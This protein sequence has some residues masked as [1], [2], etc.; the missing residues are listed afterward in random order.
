M[1][2]QQ[3]KEGLLDQI[4]HLI[5]EFQAIEEAKSSIA[6]DNRDNSAFLRAFEAQETKLRDL[7][8]ASL[9]KAS[10]K[11]PLLLSTGEIFVPWDFDACLDEMPGMAEKD[12]GDFLDFVFAPSSGDDTTDLRVKRELLLA[13]CGKPK[14]FVLLAFLR[15]GSHAQL[16][17]SSVS[18]GDCV[19]AVN[20]AEKFLEQNPLDGPWDWMFSRRVQLVIA[21]R[22]GFKG[23]RFLS[24]RTAYSALELES[25]R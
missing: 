8:M 12:L 7:V 2:T 15:Q 1:A 17:D 14:L 19:N 11:R 22:S 24:F 25:N 9:D 20:A 4:K 13:T 5:T 18:P 3:E 6:P 16:C 23:E 21:N 10:H